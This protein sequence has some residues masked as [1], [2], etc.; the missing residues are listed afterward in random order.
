VHVTSE[1]LAILG[2]AF[3]VV[4]A[5]VGV[6]W[7]ASRRAAR[8]ELLVGVWVRGLDERLGAMEDAL[9]VK[10]RPRAR[11]EPPGGV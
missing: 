4:V 10:P 9:G 6:A 7:R 3:S 1:A 11:S 2:G 5:I 8:F